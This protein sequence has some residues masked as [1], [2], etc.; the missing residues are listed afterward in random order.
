MIIKHLLDKR[1]SKIL[2]LIVIV[3]V[4]ILSLV[5]LQ[6]LEIEVPSGTDKLVHIIMYFSVSTLALWSYSTG[7]TQTIQIVLMVITYSI[8]IEFLQEYMPLKRSGD[9]NDV[10]A[11]I[12]G[13]FLGIISQPI[14][15]KIKEFF[16]YN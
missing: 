6:R 3:C 7:K 13:V 8:F 14:L 12:I 10:I 9:F 11:N 5:P 2:L 15:K 1:T 16:L 4:T